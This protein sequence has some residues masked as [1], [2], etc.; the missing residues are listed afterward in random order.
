VIVDPAATTP[1]T[2]LQ[3]ARIYARRN[4]A[5]AAAVLREVEAVAPPAAA[6]AVS[7][8][9]MLGSTRMASMAGTRPIALSDVVAYGHAMGTP[10][11]PREIMLVMVMDAAA[12][13]EVEHEDAQRKRRESARRTQAED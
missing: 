12:R 9:A 1:R 5:Q 10:L 11:T 13:D 2:R 4:P 6:F 7:A 8:F 3:H